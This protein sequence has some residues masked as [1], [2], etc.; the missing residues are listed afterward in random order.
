M[1]I[2]T[3]DRLRIYFGRYLWFG[4]SITWNIL[5]S[6]GNDPFLFIVAFKKLYFE[7]N[8][9]YSFSR[10]QTVSNWAPEK[11][12]NQSGRIATNLDFSQVSY[13]LFLRIIPL[14]R[15]YLSIYLFST[16]LAPTASIPF[17]MTQL[18]SERFMSGQFLSLLFAAVAAASSQRRGSSNSSSSSWP[19]RR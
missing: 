10:N 6:P 12:E 5:I 17:W 9:Q 4:V 8:L 11:S 18:L 13:L 2:N 3:M 1:K 14:L 19:R 7:N 15:K 16:S